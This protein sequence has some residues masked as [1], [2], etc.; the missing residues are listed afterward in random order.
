MFAKLNTICG[1]DS[2]THDSGDPECF[3][4]TDSGEIDE[5]EDAEQ[6]APFADID[7]SKTQE[8]VEHKRRRRRMAILKRKAKLKGY[9]FTNGSDVAGVLFLEIQRITD[10]PPERNGMYT[11]LVHRTGGML[12]S[13][14]VTRT[15]FDMDPFVVTSLGRK[16]F[17]TRG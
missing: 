6:T 3:D 13:F 9:E 12:T 8:T 17:R 16:T 5:D 11:S 4:R 10:L 7:E 1:I 14:I 15:S 2:P